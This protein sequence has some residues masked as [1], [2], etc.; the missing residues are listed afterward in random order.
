MKYNSITPEVFNV[1]RKNHKLPRQGFK[2]GRTNDRIETGGA[3]MMIIKC[4]GDACAAR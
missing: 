3:R 2:V 4:G 1:N